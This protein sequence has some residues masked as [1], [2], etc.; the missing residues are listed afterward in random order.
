MAAGV[1]TKLWNVADIV[2]VVEEWEKVRIISRTNPLPVAPCKCHGWR[3]IRSS[4]NRP[5]PPLLLLLLLLLLPP[6]PPAGAAA[7]THAL[8]PANAVVA[9]RT[10]GMG[11]LPLDGNFTRFDGKLTYDAGDRRD[12]RVSLQVD[13]ASLAMTNSAIRDTILG[14]EFMDAAQFPTLRFTGACQDDGIAGEL[15]MHGVTRPFALSLEHDPTRLT[16]EGRLRRADW[17]MTARPLVGGSTVRI[18]VSVRL[19]DGAR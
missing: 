16:A 2:A 14:P 15:L 7:R 11:L 19:A 8:T 10:Y 17:G 1:T 18:T 4:M 5:A 13:V 6:T 9:I 3:P 12:C